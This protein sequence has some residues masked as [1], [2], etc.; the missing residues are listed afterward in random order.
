MVLIFLLLSLDIKK[1]FI[2]NFGIMLQVLLWLLLGLYKIQISV[3][4]FFFL[5]ETVTPSSLVPLK[6]EFF[7]L[8]KLW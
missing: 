1:I 7:F 4:L 8:K 2:V 3:Y 6:G 5:V